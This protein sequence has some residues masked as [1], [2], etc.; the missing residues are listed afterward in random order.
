M[1]KGK[2]LALDYGKK[3]IGVASGDLEMKI[4]FPRQII[5]NRGIDYV[6]DSVLT[7]CEKLGASMLIVGLPLNMQDEQMENAIMKDVKIFVDAFRKA[8]GDK[9]EVSFFDERLSS[10]EAQS[11]ATDA[12]K[13]AKGEKLLVDA[14][15]AQIILQRYFDKL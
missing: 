7:L 8:A 5:E 15:A 1:N 11:L 12:K 10:F 2:V 9:I 14:Y 13:P 4:A 6:I 3:R